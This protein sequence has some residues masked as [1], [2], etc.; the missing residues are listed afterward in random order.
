MIEAILKTHECLKLVNVRMRIMK[1]G[2][3]VDLYIFFQKEKHGEKPYSSAN[4]IQNIKP[5]SNII[6]DAILKSIDDENSKKYYMICYRLYIMKGKRS[7]VKKFADKL[8]ME[9]DGN[10][11]HQPE[12]EIKRF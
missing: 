9:K 10:A 8:S 1:D 7:L 11:K 12:C 6:S 3:Y 5:A 4:S 2:K